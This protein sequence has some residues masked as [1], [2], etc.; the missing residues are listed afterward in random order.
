MKSHFLLQPQK[1]TPWPPRTAPNSGLHGLS[2]KSKFLAA[3]FFGHAPQGGKWVGFEFVKTQFMEAAGRNEGALRVVGVMQ[4]AVAPKELGVELGAIR[5]LKISIPG[6]GV[7]IVAVG[8]EKVV[9][10]AVNVDEAGVGEH[11]ELEPD[12]GGVW[13]RF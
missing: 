11:L 6:C 2:A 3:K 4:G 9:G 7:P 5:S 13:W 8:A 1:S 12:A 10:M